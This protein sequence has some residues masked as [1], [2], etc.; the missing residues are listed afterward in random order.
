[1]A[2]TTPKPGD[3]LRAHA[4]DLRSGRLTWVQHHPMVLNSACMLISNTSDGTE[5]V[6][7]TPDAVGWEE[8]VALASITGVDRLSI[9]SVWHDAEGRTKD[10]VISALEA[11]ADLLDKEGE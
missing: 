4:N 2:T 9:A 8:R 7:A 5:Y 1:M 10:E 3:R 6:V 11:A